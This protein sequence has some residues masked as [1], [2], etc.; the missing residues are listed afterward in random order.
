MDNR[1]R[2]LQV[3]RGWISRTRGDSRQRPEQGSRKERA[4]RVFRYPLPSE[5]ESI[6]FVHRSE[7]R[8]EE[9]RKE[10]RADQC[11]ARFYPTVQ[12]QRD[13]AHMCSKN[14]RNVP[15]RCCKE[16]TRRLY[17]AGQRQARM[18]SDICTSPSAGYSD[19]D[20]QRINLSQVQ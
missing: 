15:L 2:G 1:Y 8:E 10:R 16:D 13:L 11:I 6:R 18:H 9:K 17:R 7:L 20:T 14:S 12:D 3:P 5:G 4:A 19:G